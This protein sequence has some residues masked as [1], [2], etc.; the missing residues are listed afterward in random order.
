[1]PTSQQQESATGQEGTDDQRQPRPEAVGEPACPSR[2]DR[3]R[4]HEWQRR[5]SRLRRRVVLHL[6]Q[7][8]GEQKRHCRKRGVKKERQ[9]IRAAEGAGSEQCERRDRIV[10]PALEDD[11]GHECDRPEQQGKSDEGQTFG[12]CS[13]RVLELDGIA[14]ANNEELST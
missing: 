3:H 2:E 13:Q 6:D 11:E 12:L 8:E 5:R 9:Q 1:M 10:D 7:V 4:R 14:R